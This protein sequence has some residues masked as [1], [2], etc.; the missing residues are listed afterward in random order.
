MYVGN[1]P[2]ISAFQ[3][4]R[5]KNQESFKVSL[6]YIPSQNIINQLRKARE[7]AGNSGPQLSHVDVFIHS[8]VPPSHAYIAGICFPNSILGQTPLSGSQH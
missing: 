6:G 4:L 3:R 2:I 7:R 1:I 5:Q 8:V